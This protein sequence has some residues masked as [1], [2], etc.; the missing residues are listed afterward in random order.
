MTD[1]PIIDLPRSDYRWLDEKVRAIVARLSMPKRLLCF[2]A[3]VIS[4]ATAPWQL[5]YTAT[6]SQIGADTLVSAIGLIG[7]GVA[8]VYTA[9][10]PGIIAPAPRQEP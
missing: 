3:G 1:G 5:W 7:A 2:L 4:A 6:V 10:R 9:F 8:L